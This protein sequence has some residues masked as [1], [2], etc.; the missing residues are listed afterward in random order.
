MGAVSLISAARARVA[1]Y[2]PYY[3]Q[4][5][6]SFVLVP[7][8]NLG[9]FGGLGSIAVDKECRL[10]FDPEKIEKYTVEEVAGDLI[11]EM[12]HILRFHFDRR[13][14]YERT[15]FNYAG[16]FAINCGLRDDLQ[17]YGKDKVKPYSLATDYPF[18]GHMG[19]PDNL[20]AE[21]YAE[22]IL[23][24]RQNLSRARSCGSCATGI[25]EPWEDGFSDPSSEKGSGNAE[26]KTDTHS[27][28]LTP[29]EVQSLINAVAA[30]IMSVGNAPGNLRKLAEKILKPQIP[31]EKELR[32][33][34]S[35]SRV[36]AEGKHDYT[37]N[38]R[39]TR[40]YVSPDVIMPGL[41]GKKA[42]ITALIDTSGSMGYAET[43]AAMTELNGIFKSS[44]EC[45]I[46]VITGDTEPH[47]QARVDRLSKVELIGG[48]GTDMAAL[49]EAASK[50]RPPPDIIIC[51]TDGET[52]WPDRNLTPG[53]RNIIV[54]TGRYPHYGTPPSWAKVI[55]VKLGED[56]GSIYGNDGNA[57]P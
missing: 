16:D 47:F 10:Y 14:N 28:G 49:Y 22:L 19:F 56:S 9:G 2:F 55:P 51:L 17:T 38:K 32:T 24:K 52:P 20:S 23:K 31:W 25:P 3:S 57:H 34:V 5:L 27:P 26:E 7:K 41:R 30:D 37:Y 8:T 6:F 53:A 29:D 18:P 54:L 13:G 48:G 45:W 42:N 46:T 11:H 33:V 50:Q 21:R 40:G 12:G 1:H 39:S 36:W 44:S 4:L 43:N 15:L 35:N